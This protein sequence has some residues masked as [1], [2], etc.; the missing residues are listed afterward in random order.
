[1]Y[2]D[3][4]RRATWIIQDEYANQKFNHARQVFPDHDTYNFFF[5][6]NFARATARRR[7]F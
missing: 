1:M 2:R 3:S 5:L 4:A 6:K 7:G